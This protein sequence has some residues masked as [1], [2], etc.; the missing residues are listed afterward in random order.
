MARPSIFGK[1]ILRALE[2][3]SYIIPAT[4]TRAL[5]SSKISFPDSISHSDSLIKER[6]LLLE[7]AE[8]EREKGLSISSLR[9]A[10]EFL[11]I[12][13]PNK[14]LNIA[15]ENIYNAANS[16]KLIQGILK[17]AE[18]PSLIFLSVDPIVF[19]EEEFGHAF[20]LCV[21]EDEIF[22]CDN[23][24]N[25]YDDDKT[26][27]N[28]YGNAKEGILE[29]A[30]ELGFKVQTNRKPT[31]DER[32]ICSFAALEIISIASK[33]ENPFKFLS[34]TDSLSKEE[35]DKLFPTESIE[36]L[37]FFR[38]TFSVDESERKIENSGRV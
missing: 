9:K 21:G 7:K 3:S 22:L 25:K 20:C 5:S 38:S 33:V 12:F 13:K 6:E 16:K 37:T 10:I 30:K 35:R 17:R 24:G 4:F 23:N 34:E 11:E 32:R 28:S 19:G 14:D 18:K 29:G 15:S 2:N 36:R 27:P 26:E 1:I 31:F 8:K